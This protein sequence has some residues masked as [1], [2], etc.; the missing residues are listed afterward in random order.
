MNF[1]YFSNNSTEAAELVSSGIGQ[2]CIDIERNGKTDRQKGR[3]TFISTHQLEDIRDMVSSLGSERV[4]CRVNPIYEGSR[5]EISKSIDYG[6]SSIILPYFRHLS[7]VERFLS[8]L[9]GRA[10]STLLIE[11]CHSFMLIPELVKI[12]SVD[13]LYIGLNDLSLDCGISNM[14]DLVS[15]GW[16]EIAASLIAGQMPFGFGGISSLND[17][18]CLVDPKTILKVHKA[19]GTNSLILSRSFFNCCKLLSDQSGLPY[20]QVVGSEISLI[21]EYLEE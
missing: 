20:Q 19:I 5:E 10:K 12:T 15:N 13:S 8:I 17:S 21:S 9:D 18:S 16:M 7:E 3:N 4:I 1:W 11:T 6:A 14:I 2:V